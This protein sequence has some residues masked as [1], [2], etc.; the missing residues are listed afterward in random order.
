MLLS[1]VNVD[2]L[3]YRPPT[4]NAKGGKVVNVSTV[5]GSSDYN[6]RLRFQMSED[7]TA[8]GLQTAVWGLATP[9]GANDTS[10]RTL[11][12]TINN[13]TSLETLLNALDSKNIS[14]ATERSPEWFRKEIDIE[15]IRSMYVPLVKPPAKPDACSTVKVKV[16]CESEQYPTNIFVVH[17]VDENGQLTY[18]TGT[19][20]DL[21][22]NAKCL[23]IVETVGLWF[24]QRQ[25]G[26]SLTATEIM[27]W[28]VKKTRGIDAFKMSDSIKSLS[29]SVATAFDVN[30]AMDDGI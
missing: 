9:L 30:D 8:S 21:T 12:L 11:E 15:A 20:D 29:P 1:A 16:K 5:P 13:S 3:D 28:P 4:T 23:V 26:M 6:D 22:R 18:S 14:I 19:T 17:G 2:E 7:E 10:R 24:M 27:V 25:F